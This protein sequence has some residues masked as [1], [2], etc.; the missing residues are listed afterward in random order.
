[1]RII[2]VANVR[3]HNAT[4]WYAL[5][6]A[7]LLQ[8]AGHEVLM[9]CLQDTE[10][11]QRARDLGLP[12]TSLNL[13][14]NNPLSLAAAAANLVRLV[15]S[16]R[17]QVVN[18]HRGESFFLWAGL[19]RLGFPY[20]LVRTRGDQRLPKSGRINRWLHDTVADA[21]VVTNRRMA[22]YFRT[23]MRI[24]PEKLWIIR[25]GVDTHRFAFDPEGRDRVRREFGFTD[26]H[27]VIG[28][29]GRFD[30]VKGQKELIQA[31]SKLRWDL[32][33]KNVR[34]MLVGFESAVKE[35]RV[36]SWLAEYDVAD[37]TAVTGRRSDVPACYSALDLAVV[38]SLYSEAIARAPLELMAAHRPIISTKVGVLPDLLDPEALVPPG[39]TPALVLKIVECLKH[40]S[41]R[42]RMLSRQRLTLSQHTL[43][44]FL[45]R[46]L[47][48]YQGVLD[49][50][51]SL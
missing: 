3:W 27:T 2:Q 26:Q 19:R 33:M 15:K 23:R 32:E 28:L 39:D 16:F 25:G 45:R 8:N 40:E 38:A 6:L 10:P 35:S 34:L 11:Y 30:E 24:T 41:L 12:V 4:A 37:I 31:V 48:L 46:S 7:D 50:E 42:D 47:N 9:V 51:A 13:N 1:M 44:E 20:K 5:T 18:C 14:S 17:P 36:R 49:P 29:A 22:E 21:V 43:E